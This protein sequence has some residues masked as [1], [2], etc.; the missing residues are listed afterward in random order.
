MITTP[1]Y[2]AATF[3]Q[4]AGL[5]LRGAE[6][7]GDLTKQLEHPSWLLVPLPF[8]VVVNQD[9]NL[10]VQVCA[11]AFAIASKLLPF[12]EAIIPSFIGKPL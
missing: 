3:G 10:G 4:F 8:W 11:I 9:L 1:L 2:I 7:H 5:N 6:S 12:P